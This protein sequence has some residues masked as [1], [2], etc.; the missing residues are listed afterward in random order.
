ML[1]MSWFLK[2]LGISAKDQKIGKSATRAAKAISRPAA[3]DNAPKSPA[4]QRTLK[5]TILDIED[6]PYDEYEIVGESHYQAILGKHAGP[7]TEAGADHECVVLLVCE[8]GNKYDKNAVRVELA[9][10]TVGYLSRN[11]AESFREMLDDEDVRGAK[12]KAKARITGGW[13]RDDDEGHFGIALDL[14]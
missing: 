12:V 14:D 7:K 4:K 11:D 2:L 3:K 6:L 5:N 1:S 8:R 10:E 9:G 13:K